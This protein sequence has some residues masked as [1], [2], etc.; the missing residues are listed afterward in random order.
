MNLVA[1]T[2]LKIAQCSMVSALLLKSITTIPALSA[3]HGDSRGSV[4]DFLFFGC[5][6]TLYFLLIE[7]HCIF[8]TSCKIFP[9]YVYCYC[10]ILIRM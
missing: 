6:S 2:P 5:S 9:C 3:Y 1:Q 7:F 10:C 4:D 8:F